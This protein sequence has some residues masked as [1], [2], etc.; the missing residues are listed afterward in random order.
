MRDERGLFKALP[1]DNWL[2]PWKTT[3]VLD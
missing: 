2:M 1:P 3:W